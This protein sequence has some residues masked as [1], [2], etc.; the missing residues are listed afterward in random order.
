MRIVHKVIALHSQKNNFF[1]TSK[2]FDIKLETAT[3][4][5]KKNKK[6]TEKGVYWLPI[7]GK[8]LFKEWSICK[9]CNE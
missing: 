4:V 6:K 2:I 9:T 7:S 5:E 8:E 1:L 3:T